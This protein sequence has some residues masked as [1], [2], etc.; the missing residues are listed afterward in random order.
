MGGSTRTRTQL[1]HVAVEVLRASGSRSQRR[2]QNRGKTQAVRPLPD[3]RRIAPSRRAPVSRQSALA[4]RHHGGCPISSA[5]VSL[6]RPIPHLSEY[7]SLVDIHEA[8]RRATSGTAADRTKASE[9]AM[10]DHPELWAFYQR[11]RMGID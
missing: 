1:K 9:Q 8:E 6:R 3:G 4:H 5:S 2:R 7:A 10:T 11:A